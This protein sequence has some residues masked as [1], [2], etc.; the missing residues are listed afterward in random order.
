M[1]VSTGPPPD[2]LDGLV[3]YEP[4]EPAAEGAEAEAEEEEEM[5][6]E[7]KKKTKAER[8]KEVRIRMSYFIHV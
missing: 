5:P 2:E 7:Q 8:N 4:D 1:D 3:L 6:V